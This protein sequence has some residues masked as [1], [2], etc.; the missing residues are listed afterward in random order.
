MLAS[1]S[2]DGLMTTLIAGCG[3]LA[4]PH[5]DPDTRYL[6]RCVER[7]ELGLDLGEQRLVGRERR[8]ESAQWD[9]AVPWHGRFEILHQAG[10]WS[11]PR[12]PAAWASS[13]AD[14][15]K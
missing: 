6:A 12:T 15:A 13:S 2:V 9:L 3:G 7:G 10:S 4:S 14:R 1:E 8:D 11:R 5:H